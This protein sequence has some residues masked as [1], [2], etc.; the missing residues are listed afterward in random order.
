MLLQSN[1]IVFVLCLF[2]GKQEDLYWR[3]TEK[4]IEGCD[5]DIQKCQLIYWTWPVMSL[6]GTLDAND[7][8]HR[9]LWSDGSDCHDSLVVGFRGSLEIYSVLEEENEALLSFD[10]YE[11]SLM[12]EDNLWYDQSHAEDGS[13]EKYKA[14]FMAHGFIEG[15]NRLWGDSCSYGQIHFDYGTSCKA[16]MEATPDGREDSLFECCNC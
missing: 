9:V 6:S 4:S 1:D 7:A 14:R 11:A 5:Q 10:H 2:I 8:L 3:W 15:R 16:R 12:D 13:I